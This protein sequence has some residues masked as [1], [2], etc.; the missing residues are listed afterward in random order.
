LVGGRNGRPLI[1]RR[2]RAVLR[3]FGARFSSRQ[4]EVRAKDFFGNTFFAKRS[5][6]SN[7]FFSRPSPKPSG[8]GAEFPPRTPLPL[9]PS[10]WKPRRTARIPEGRNRAEKYPLPF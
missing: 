1:L 2:I 7:L 8:D 6:S 9:R 5:F 10:E 3:A 4:N